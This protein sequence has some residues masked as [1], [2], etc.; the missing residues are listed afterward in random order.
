MRFTTADQTI[1]IPAIGAVFAL[2]DVYEGV[3]WFVR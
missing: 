3:E 2:A 1:Y